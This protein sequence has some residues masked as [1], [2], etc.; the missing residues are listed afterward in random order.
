MYQIID[1]CS[2]IL[3]L[4]MFEGNCEIDHISQTSC[5]VSQRWKTNIYHRSLCTY[6]CKTIT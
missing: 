4:H 1:D 3:Y 6:K 2:D 5:Y